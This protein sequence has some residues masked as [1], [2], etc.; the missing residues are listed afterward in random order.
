MTSCQTSTSL[1]P[2]TYPVTATYS[3]DSDYNG[4]AAT[5]ATFTVTK[6]DPSFTEFAAPSTIAYGTQD[7]LSITGLAG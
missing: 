2:G 4:T 7:T 5:G 3:G 6:A 1:A